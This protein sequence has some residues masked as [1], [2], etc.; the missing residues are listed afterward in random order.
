MLIVELELGGESASVFY[1]S[2]EE[3]LDDKGLKSLFDDELVTDCK[4]Y[5]L[6]PQ[7]IA[8]LPAMQWCKLQAVMT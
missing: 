4:V 7:Q 2:L 1:P 8:G 6:I 5:R 3:V